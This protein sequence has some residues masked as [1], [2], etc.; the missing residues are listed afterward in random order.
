M[1]RC[2]L[3]TA[4]LVRVGAFTSSL[5]PLTGSR[6]CAARL[7]CSAA[8][9]AGAAQE[10]I[11]ASEP[12]KTMLIHAGS[13]SLP[14]L[15]QVPGG[16]LPLKAVVK[17]PDADV[18]WQW[19]KTR[20]NMEADTSWASVW[21]AAANLAALI[22]RTPELVRG[23]RVCELGSGLG[24]AGLS[25]AKAGATTVTLVDR[26]ALALHCAM[27]TAE[28]CG[29]RLGPVL[30]LRRSISLTLS[31]HPNSN[32]N[33]VCGLRTGPVPDGSDDAKAFYAQGSEAAAAA[34][35]EAEAAAGKTAQLRAAMTAAAAREDYAEAAALK[36]ELAALGPAGVVSAS[37]ADWSDLAGNG[38]VVDVVLA[39]EVLYDPREAAPL[40]RSAA[41][42]LSVGGTL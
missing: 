15:V 31:L 28:V 33:Q 23:L 10:A 25:A 19:E 22:A 1:L 41:A 37:M 14:P 36:Q 11:T 9:D 42:L 12:D 40:A 4:V 38:L 21:P 5:R 27:S 39:S 16:F 29:L 17:P 20:G 8:A 7:M 3:A 26:E 30:S 34:E 24:V 6:A 32:P 13:A 18:L 35:A 2:L